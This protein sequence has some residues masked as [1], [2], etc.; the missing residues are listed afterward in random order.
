VVV[1]LQHFCCATSDASR[2]M[3]I[4]NSKVK[5]Q[6][7]ETEKNYIID[8]EQWGLLALQHRGNW[9]SIWRLNWL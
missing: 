7:A 3:N 5:Q 1:A 8:W 6:Q 4:S 2:N 9:N